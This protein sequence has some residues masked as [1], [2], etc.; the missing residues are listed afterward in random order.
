M[1]KGMKIDLVIIDPQND[2]CDMEISGFKP[3]LAVGGGYDAMTK[4]AQLVDR[5]GNKLNDIHVTLDSHRLLDIAHP[6]FWRDTNGNPPPPFTFISSNDIK[7]GIW[8][9]RIPALYAKMLNYAELLE[10]TGKYQ[11]CI[12]PPHCLIGTWGHAVQPILNEALQNWSMKE[13]ATVDYVTKGSNPYTEHYGA[14][15]AEVPDASDPGTSLNTD[16]L[17]IL[18]DS[19][20]I[21]LTGLAS[22]HCLKETG[23]QI[24]DNIGAEHI[25]KLCILT[26]CTAPVAAV[27]GGPDFPAIAEQWFKD[28]QKLGVTLT[29]SDKFLA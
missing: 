13:I 27:P 5:I 12:W 26:D 8:R 24:V 17:K 28:M 25:K 2:F 3:T 7:A 11:L 20:I 16:F 6:A 18:S 29:A 21:L 23:Q 9:P 14:L 10:A 19:D 22:S 15:M 4:V 1:K